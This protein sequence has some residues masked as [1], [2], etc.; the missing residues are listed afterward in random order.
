LTSH[1]RA[2]SLRY[3]DC[4]RP[5]DGCDLGENLATQAMTNLAERGSLGVRENHS[6]FQRL[7]DAVFGRQISFR[8]SSSWSTV[9][10][11]KARTH[12]RPIHN[13]LFAPIPCTPKNVPER[14][15]TAM[16]AGRGCL[17]ETGRPSFP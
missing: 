6:A 5:G 13:G 17:K 10:V 8:A 9:P 2:T 11:T 14:L 7:S 1:L 3:Q 12:K 4:V 16:L 15:R